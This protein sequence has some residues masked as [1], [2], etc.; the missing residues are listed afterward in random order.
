MSLG[1]ATFSIFEMG[2]NQSFVVLGEKKIKIVEHINMVGGKKT[3]IA[4]W[5][6]W[7]KQGSFLT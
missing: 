7:I 3:N 6:I 2:K 1:A 4:I 5:G